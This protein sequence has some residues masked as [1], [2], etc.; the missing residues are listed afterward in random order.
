[1]KHWQYKPDFVVKDLMV[2]ARLIQ[3]LTAE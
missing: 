3:S 2:A 1:M